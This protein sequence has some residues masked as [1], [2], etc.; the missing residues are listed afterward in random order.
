MS[1]SGN[2]AERSARACPMLLRAGVR[3]GS[4]PRRRAGEEDQAV[5]A[6]PDLVTVLEQRVVDPAAVHVGAVGAADVVDRVGAALAPELHVPSG[7]GDVVE[8]DLAL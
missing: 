5:L 7:D 6:D 1:S 2:S 8:E 4:L 3:T